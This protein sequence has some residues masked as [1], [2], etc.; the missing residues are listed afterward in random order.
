MDF[1]GDTLAS[2]RTFRTLNLVDDGSRECPAIEVDF[3]LSGE[4]VTRVLDNVA[5]T[6]PLPKVIVVDNGPEFT[7]KALDAWAYR[8]GVELHFIRPGKPVDNAFIESFNG[9]FR[10]ECLNENW[11]QDLE[12]ARQKIETWRPDYNTVRPH[13]ALGNRTPAEYAA[14]VGLAG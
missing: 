14:A 9:K 4:R 8:H 1:M 6:Q 10:D 12:D 3:G 11:F 7:S 5:K 13:S 2:G